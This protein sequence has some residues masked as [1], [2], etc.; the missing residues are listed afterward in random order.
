MNMI[1]GTRQV[2]RKGEEETH[3]WGSDP[4]KRVIYGLDELADERLGVSVDFMD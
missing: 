2:M 3:R 1:Q 4:E